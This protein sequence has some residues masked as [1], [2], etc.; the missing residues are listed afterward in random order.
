MMSPRKKKTASGSPA[1]AAQKRAAKKS[2]GRK[3]AS[4]RKRRW[5]WSDESR[6]KISASATQTWQ[7]PV[8]RERRV[9]GIRRAMKT[10][11]V[12]ARIL[13]RSEERR[14]RKHTAATIR[15]MRASALRQRGRKKTAEKP[16]ARKKSAS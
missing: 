14:G 3:K 11:E 6:A 7:D 2:V 5:T 16:A 15:K 4:A 9:E 13:E 12:R 8:V 10:P 1:S